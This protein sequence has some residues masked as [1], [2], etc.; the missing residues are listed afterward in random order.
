[1]THAFATIA[2][3]FSSSR[4]PTVEACLKDFG[5]PAHAA[6]KGPLDEAE[7]VHFVSMTVVR[8]DPQ[9]HLVVEMSADGTVAEA[10][11]RLA[12][13]LAQPL[14]ALLETTG[15]ER[16]EVSLGD[17]LLGKHVPVGQGWF[18]NPGLN[19]DGTPG[20]T[21]ERIRK[22]EKLAAAAALLVDRLER[23]RKED[24]EV[25][26]SPL[27]TLNAVRE[28]LW[29]K[30]EMKWAFVADDA[31]CLEGPPPSLAG[32]PGL[33]AA[34]TILLW[35][36]LLVAFA[37]LVLVCW[38]LRDL[39]A[40]LWAALIVLLAEAAAI[41]WRLRQK[42]ETDIPL[43]IAP[44]AA[45]VEEFMKRENF[46]A[47][48]HLAAVSVMKP[49]RFRMFTLRVGLWA[50][51]QVGARFSRPSF[52][53]PTG[54]IHF[55]R[56]LILPGTNKLLFYSN[57]DGAWESY[58]EN[59]IEQ[60]Y[61]G[62]NGIWS[63]TVGFPRTDNLFGVGLFGVAANRGGNDGDRLRRWTRRQQYP[64]LVWYSGYHE[65]TT[66]RIRTN[67]A[68]RQ[69]IA[70]AATESDAADWLA[71]F[72]SEPRPAPNLETTEIPTLVF[73]GLSRQRFGASL[74]LQLSGD[75]AADKGWLREIEGGLTY[76]NALNAE[77]A[78]LVAFS[79]TGLLK[80][81]LHGSDLTTFPVA[82]QQGSAARW[83]ARAIGD[84]ADN[85]PDKW[86]WGGPDLPIDAV[87]LIYAK[88][89]KALSDAIRHRKKELAAAGIRIAHEV[90]LKELPPEVLPP[91]NQFAKEPFGFADGVSQPIIDG[92]PRAL[93]SKNAHQVVKPG[94]FVFGYP[95]NLGYMP[96]SPAVADQRDPHDML[97]ALGWDPSRQRPDFSDPAPTTSHDLGRNGTFLVVRQLEQNKAAFEDFKRAAAK[98]IEAD[99]RAPAL[100]LP[101]LEEWIGAKIVGRWEN[102][103]SLVRHPHGPRKDGEADND[104]RFG[105]E[106]PTGVRCPLGAHIRRANPRESFDPGSETQLSITNRHR[107]LR[108]GRS[109]ASQEGKSD[110]PGL[111][112][113]ALNADIERQFEFV[114]QTW[115][116]APSFHGLQN[117]VDPMI[118]RRSVSRDMTI[119]TPSGP[120]CV[121]G[122]KDFV[123]VRGSGYFFLPGRTAIRFLAR[124][125]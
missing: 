93:S 79:A 71:C 16:G 77:E 52:L 112:F 125:A 65:L 100:P 82:F 8:G 90:A 105:V 47:H 113:M 102:G 85:D 56:W 109:Y 118:G 20:M 60:A 37:A 4:T 49:G 12:S 98:K 103:Q 91:H 57:Y 104:F 80:L 14:E 24:T 10:V 7:F 108:V 42:E 3:P 38:A 99:P 66:D 46:G 51:G 123:R 115:L 44:R 58:L 72:G 107:I 39:G 27:A 35:P 18:S 116:S 124:G 74:M 9:A 106:D 43:D 96:P 95:D 53:G 30:G 87:L 22:E 62:V 76:G 117:E 31:P 75:E 110:N 88:T 13:T 23:I 101:K 54:V 32:V 83:R 41:Y 29:A 50:A 45:C 89:S 92:T 64:S 97:P 25:A 55:A 67:A 120:L 78:M 111:L 2:I 69:G 61:N 73:G 119:P 6:I 121:K 15:V 68:I 63:N 33:F 86:W 17:F 114:Q 122:L 84:V 26:P 11:T 5:N 36:F 70:L 48:N 34:S 19:Y 21:V 28:R 1:M 40:G 59:F 81:G 94:E